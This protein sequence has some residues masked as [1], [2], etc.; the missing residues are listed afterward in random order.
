MIRRMV[1]RGSFTV[2]GCRRSG[3]FLSVLGPWTRASI[4]SITA[5]SSTTMG[6]EW[7]L[8]GILA[9]KHRKMVVEWDFR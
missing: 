6:S 2:G 4:P 3:R 1:L 8:N 9:N 7:D 5:G